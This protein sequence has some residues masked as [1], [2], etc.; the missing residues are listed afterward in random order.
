VQGYGNWRLTSSAEHARIFAKN[1]S[2]YFV[3]LAD[4][5]DRRLWGEMTRPPADRNSPRVSIVTADI[6][7]NSK[8]HS[9]SIYAL[10]AR[11][12]SPLLHGYML[13]PDGYLD[14]NNGNFHFAY[15]Y[16]NPEKM[17]A[18]DF[19]NES[20]MRV[21]CVT[22]LGSRTNAV[23][24]R[25]AAAPSSNSSATFS[26]GPPAHDWSSYTPPVPVTVQAT[27][28]RLRSAPFVD[29][30]ATV[31]DAR[32]PGDSLKVVGRAVMTDWTWYR[33]ELSDGRHAYIRSDLTS[34]PLKGR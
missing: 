27:D 8:L 12:Y 13:R 24:V 1:R 18:T 26:D 16:S 6:G 20:D 9:S 19:G 31:M 25:S 4:A 5:P 2:G 29:P 23:P 30:Q 21:I 11:P 3:Y 17:M 14:G 22:D 15:G 34:A 10:P 33:V 28:A 7:D 32:Q